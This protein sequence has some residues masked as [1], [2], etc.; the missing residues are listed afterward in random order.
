MAGDRKSRRRKQREPFGRIRQLPSRRYQAGYTGPDLAPHKAASTFETL[1]DAR[2]WL[3]EERRRIDA[4][5]WTSP[6]SRNQAV[7]VATLRTY[8]AAWLADRPLK[9]ST[10]DLYSRLLEQRI[11]PILGDVPLK[12]FTPLTVR[13]WYAKLPAELPTRRAHSYALLRTI[14]GSAV[15]DDLLAA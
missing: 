1:M 3:T 13:Q 8:A 6:A 5:T 15:S 14:L 7:Q 12:D 2:G 9:P 4:G 11:L 10:R